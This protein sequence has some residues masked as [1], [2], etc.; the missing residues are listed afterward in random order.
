[1]KN[2]RKP[3]Q[4]ENTSRR[5]RRAWQKKVM[6][7]GWIF[8]GVMLTPAVAAIVLCLLP[9]RDKT[10]DT[11]D[12][13]LPRRSLT[14]ARAAAPFRR[15]RPPRPSKPARPAAGGA[16]R[17]PV[18]LR[19]HPARY[20]DA[21]RFEVCGSHGARRDRGGDVAAN[22]WG[23]VTYSVSENGSL[24]SRKPQRP[25]AHAGQLR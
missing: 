20:R 13:P 1:M 21:R 11:E 2:Y 14:P 18:R 7:A 3:R 19:L 10:P 17:Q 16:L 23:S 4:E 25:G 22:G 5:A 9:G 15:S 6:L 12:R 24:L 8:L